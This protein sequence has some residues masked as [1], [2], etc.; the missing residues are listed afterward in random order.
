MSSALVRGTRTIPYVYISNE[1]P[2]IDVFFDN[3]QVTHYRG[4]IF[5]ETHYYPFGLRMEGICSRAAGKLL[6]KN[7]FN[8]GNELQS[9][10]FSDGSGME[11]YDAV[12]RM[13]DPQLG[14]FWQ[15]DE[16]AEGNWEMTPYNFAANNPINRNDP[17]GLL[18]VDP[19][20]DPT[21]KLKETKTLQEVVIKSVRKLTPSQFQDVYWDLKN[22]GISF[23][24]VKSGAL[25][26]RLERW[27]GIERH[28]K[29][30]HS[31][32]KEDGLMMLEAASCFIPV[33]QITKVRYLKYAVTLYK[34][35]RGGQIALGVAK[36]LIARN[37]LREA[38]IGGGSDFVSQ[39][40]NNSVDYINSNDPNKGGYLSYVAG[41]WNWA[42]T[43]G[44]AIF[45]NALTT[46]VI[47]TVGDGN[48]NALPGNFIGDAIGNIPVPGSLGTGF[49]SGAS[50]TLG[51]WGNTVGSTVTDIIDP[52]K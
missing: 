51:L 33:G 16:L 29:I 25:R 26:A 31:G 36:N 7:L 32:I 39:T 4:V 9:K 42:A 6:N 44:N 18:D 10:E 23:D 43:A 28:M 52:K 2:N 45:K 1:T 11:L 15:I 3:L 22:R 19:N 41:N 21:G 5:E 46:S 12:H 24:R 47:S 14:R 34:N 20:D 17:F 40:I 27:D 38:A 8:G 35:R 37:S 13:Y 49:G 48:I 50:F 30:V